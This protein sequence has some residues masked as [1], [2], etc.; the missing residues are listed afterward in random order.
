MKATL[1]RLSTLALGVTLLLANP[2]SAAPAVQGQVKFGVHVPTYLGGFNVPNFQ[3][4]GGT[5]CPDHSLSVFVLGGQGGLDNSAPGVDIFERGAGTCHT[6]SQ[7]DSPV[8]FTTVTIN[9]LVATVS[10]SCFKIQRSAC[11]TARIPKFGGHISWTFP[12]SG[13]YQATQIIVDGYNVS[14]QTLLR[15]ARGVRTTL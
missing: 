10:T 2:A 5:Y 13:K 11:T 12:A 1:F 9:G 3:I 4:Q 7:S 6:A 14:Y 8:V 15:I